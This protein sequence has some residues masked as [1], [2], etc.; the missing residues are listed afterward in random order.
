MKEPLIN[1][2]LSLQGLLSGNMYID[3]QLQTQFY[4]HRS[5]VL[6]TLS[7]ADLKTVTK[8]LRRLTNKASL[9]MQQWTDTDN[10]SNV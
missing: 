2:R 6:V 8:L 5:E 10:W 1:Y 9:R 7:F 4:I 3:A